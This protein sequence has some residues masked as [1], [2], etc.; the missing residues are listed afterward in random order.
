MPKSRSQI[1][2]WV[3]QVMR[4]TLDLASIP[5]VNTGRRYLRAFLA[6]ED[7]AAPMFSPEAVD[8]ARL[9]MILLGVNA[10]A[11]HWPDGSQLLDNI[12]LNVRDSKERNR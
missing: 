8:N 4:D 12:L 11:P 3:E 1:V 7:Y 5:Q 6:G 9:S 10:I 2:L